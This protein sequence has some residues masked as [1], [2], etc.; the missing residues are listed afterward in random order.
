MIQG[1][2]GIGMHI[3]VHLAHVMMAGPGLV[4]DDARRAA[5]TITV[6]LLV[7]LLIHS[8]VLLRVLRRRGHRHGMRIRRLHVHVHHLRVRPAVLI[9]PPVIPTAVEAVA[10]LAAIGLLPVR[11]VSRRAAVEPPGRRVLRMHGEHGGGGLGLRRI[12]PVG[13]HV[14]RGVQAGVGVVL[15]GGLLGGIAGLLLD[16]AAAV[17]SAGAATVAVA[18]VA[19]VT[20]T[21]CC[22]GRRVALLLVALGRVLRRLLHQGLGLATG[23]VLVVWVLGHVE[24]PQPFGLVDEGPLVGLR[25]EL[26]LGAQPFANLRVVHLRVLL[27][28]LP[29]LA[30]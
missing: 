3:I 4:L 27:R 17:G 23:P 21:T 6:R 26:P 30:P 11:L 8:L 22:R 12:V 24:G 19:M 14:V 15:H 10:G 13:G 29:A 25:E 18:V 2:N 7:L 9:A 1:G 20:A 5:A 28:H 16:L